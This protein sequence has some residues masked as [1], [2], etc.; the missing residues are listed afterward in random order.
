MLEFCGM[1]V[2]LFRVVFVSLLLTACGGSPERE[3]ETV[4]TSEPEPEITLNLP[5]SECDCSRQQQ[6][7]TFLE[8]G[9][10]S[11]EVAEYLD[12]LQYFQRYQRIEKTLTADTEARIAIAYLSILPESPIYDREAAR[13]SYMR[14]RGKLDPNLELHPEILLMR[15]SL[16]TFIDIQQVIFA[17]RQS[18]RQGHSL[19]SEQTPEWQSP[20]G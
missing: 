3:Q 6:D 2:R 12:A 11:L 16:E 18:A 4:S 8:R 20:A 15:D 19:L 9:F 1:D 17:R 14:I 5:Q 10:R 7:Y 13:E